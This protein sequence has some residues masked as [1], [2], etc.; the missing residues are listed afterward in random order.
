MALLNIKHN[1]VWNF[2]EINSDIM[3]TIEVISAILPDD[4]LTFDDGLY[5]CWQFIDRLRA[6]PNK[7]IFYITT[8]IVNT[9]GDINPEFI[10]CHDAH[11]N[12]FNNSFEGQK[13]YM[14]WD[15]IRAISKMGNCFIGMHG[16]QHLNPANFKG[17][18]YKISPFKIDVQSMITTFQKELPDYNFSQYFQPPYNAHDPIYESILT[19][20]LAAAGL[21]KDFI[22]Y[23]NRLELSQNQNIQQ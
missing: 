23:N 11:R 20:E 5:S 3:N 4:I 18:K 12:Y 1:N 19:L 22:T 2:H 21:N 10:R 8:D 7:K 9:S 17:F 14:S 6:L 13:H 16:A 15:N